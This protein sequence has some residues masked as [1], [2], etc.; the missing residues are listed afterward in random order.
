MGIIKDTLK[1]NNGDVIYPKTTSDQVLDLE[2]TVVNY[3]KNNGEIQTKISTEANN[4]IN[5]AL[6]GGGSIKN[7]IDAAVSDVPAGPSPHNLVYVSG[8]P[9]AAV[10]MNDNGSKLYDTETFLYNHVVSMMIEGGSMPL[11]ITF[12]LT[13]KKARSILE[14]NDLRKCLQVYYGGNGVTFEPVTDEGAAVNNNGV[15]TCIKSG[16]N[17]TLILTFITL[18][19][20]TGLGVTDFSI[21]IDKVGSINDT[22]IKL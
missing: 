7:A 10:L 15:A 4:T 21:T 1:L 17:N 13:L 12:T 5:N 11:I 18:S 9:D 19:N 14:F 22:V 8:A 2:N 16:S 3:V 20:D 6:E